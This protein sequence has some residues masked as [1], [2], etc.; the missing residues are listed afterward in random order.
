M[1]IGLTELCILPVLKQMVYRKV[2][3]PF[4]DL[5]T[6]WP[7]PP[8]GCMTLNQ[9]PLHGAVSPQPDSQVQES[10]DEMEVVPTH[11]YNTLVTY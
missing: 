8:A 1:P 9:C 4:G 10:S 6:V 7:R 11:Y 2:E 3:W 5:V